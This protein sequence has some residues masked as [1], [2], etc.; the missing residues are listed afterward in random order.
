MNKYEIC[1]EDKIIKKTYAYVKR[2][3]TLLSLIHTNLGDLK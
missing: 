1:V 2:E 3:T